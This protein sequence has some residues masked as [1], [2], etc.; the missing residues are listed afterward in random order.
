[1][2]IG[3]RI[4]AI[5]TTIGMTQKQLGE[6]SSMADSAIRKYESGKINPKLETIRKIA[7]ALEVPVLT[8]LEETIQNEME[9]LPMDEQK[10]EYMARMIVNLLADMKCPYYEADDVLNVA[11]D[12]IVKGSV[13]HVDLPDKQRIESDRTVSAFAVFKGG[14]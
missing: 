6:R 14:L 1:M 5:R 9:M 8:L 11:S 3:Q 10:K 4:R 12:M 7:E 2:T 13:A